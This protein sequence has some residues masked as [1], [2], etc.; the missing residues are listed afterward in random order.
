MLQASFKAKPNDQALI[1]E[2]FLQDTITKERLPGANV[3]LMDSAV[4]MATDREGYFNIEVDATEAKIRLIDEKQPV[5]FSFI[6]YR[7]LE[8]TIGQLINNHS[9]GISIQSKAGF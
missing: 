3:L 4:G 1:L 9:N 2:G 7:R 5:H 6:G 8:T